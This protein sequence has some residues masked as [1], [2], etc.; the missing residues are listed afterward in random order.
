VL[1]TSPGLN[2]DPPGCVLA[3]TCQPTA[4]KRRRAL[5]ICQSS[6]RFAMAR[7]LLHVHQVV[8]NRECRYYWTEFRREAIAAYYLIGWCLEAILKRHRTNSSSHLVKSADDNAV[9]TLPGEWLRTFWMCTYLVEIVRFWI[10]LN[11]IL[12][13]LY[14]DIVRDSPYFIYT[15]HSKSGMC[16]WNIWIACTYRHLRYRA[17]QI[18]I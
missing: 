11:G 13:A 5:S 15:C 9:T 2:V 12:H 6:D 10:T 16:R 14:I 17:L 4:S 18:D 3:R 8:R 1:P 7:P